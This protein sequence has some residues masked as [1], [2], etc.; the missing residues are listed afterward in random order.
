MRRIILPDSVGL[1]LLVGTAAGIGTASA[2]L[3]WR[4]MGEASPMVACKPNGGEL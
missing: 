1:L 2:L 3:G 4:D